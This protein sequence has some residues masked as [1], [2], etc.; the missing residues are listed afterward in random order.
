MSGCCA[1][2]GSCSHIGP[3]V[4][5]W[6]HAPNGMHPYGGLGITWTSS[7]AWTEWAHVRRCRW[8]CRVCGFTA[9]HH[10]PVFF[11]RNHFE[12]RHAA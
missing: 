2:A 6:A 8:T 1:C 7:S 10:D 5:C 11:I 12:R 3:H 4:Y 9:Q